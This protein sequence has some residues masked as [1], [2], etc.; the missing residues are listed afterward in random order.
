MVGGADSRLP[1][2][3]PPPRTDL[4][5]GT[6]RPA[7]GAEV[8][9]PGNLSFFPAAQVHP[10]D[11]AR[12]PFA[13]SPTSARRRPGRNS[14][15]PDRGKSIV[16]AG[17]A[18]AG[19]TAPALAV[20]LMLASALTL[21]PGAARAQDCGNPDSDGVIT[22]ADQA[23]A[24]G[25]SESNGN[26]PFT[27]VVGGGAATTVTAPTGA[28]AGILATG[29][30]G[31]TGNN[32]LIRVGSAGAVRIVKVAPPGSHR[33]RGVHL[34]QQGSGTATIDVRDTVTIGSLSNPM[35]GRGIYLHAQGAGAASIVS[36]AT[37]Y[38]TGSRDGIFLHRTVATSGATTITNSGDITVGIGVNGPPVGGDGLEFFYGQNAA[39]GAGSVSITNRGKIT[40]LGSGRGIRYLS[41]SYAPSSGLTVTNHGE[42]TATGGGYGM[43]MFFAAPNQAITGDLTIDNRGDITANSAFDIQ[44]FGQ[45]NLALMNTGDIVSTDFHGIR[46]SI[47]P[48]S[49]TSRRMGD[50]TV[51]SSG[52][53]SASGAGYRGIYAGTVGDGAVRVTARGGEIR[54]AAA[55]GIH[56]ESQGT[57]AVTVS[58]GADVTAATH[59]I[60]AEKTGS[61][62]TAGDVSVTATGGSIMA[63]TDGIRA[64]WAVD[65]AGNGGIEVTVDEGASVT[66]GAVGVHVANAGT[67]L[68]VR[69]RYT[70][71]FAMG[72][73]PDELVA[74][75]HGE[76]GSAV[77]LRNQLV[78]V[79]G[80]VTGGTGAAIHLE[81]GGGVLV[82]E[83]GEVRA[84]SSGVGIVAVGGP[85][86]VYVD[87]EVRGGAGGAAAVDLGGGGSVTVG[88]NGR[89][90]ANG[91]ASAIR[92]AV[93]ETVTVTLVIDRL[94]PYREDVEARLAGAL[95]GIESVR[96]REDRDGVPT[97]YDYPE[98]LQV[99]P[100]GRLDT[101][102]L[103]ARL[104]F[105]CGAAGD[106][107]CRMYEALPSMLLAMSALPSRAERMSAPRDARGGW[108]RVEVS[109]GEWRAKKAATAA[110]LAYDHS[111]VVARAGMDFVPRE[112]LRVGFS[113]HAPR[114][115]AEMPGVGE[116]ELDGVG[117]GVS[118]AWRF[119]DLYVDAQA[120]VTRY[121]VG[122]DSY[123][124]GKLLK[125]DASGVGYALGAEAGKRMPVGGAF[126]TPRAGLA[127]SKVD[128][129]EFTDLETAGGPGRSRVSLEDAGSV[130]GRV[131]VTVEKE[132][133]TGAAPGLLFGSLDVE[134]EFSDETEVKVGGQM[135]KTEVQPTAV[136]LGAGAMFDVRENVLMRAVAGYRASEGGASGYGGSLEVRVRF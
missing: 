89:V 107:R 59:G 48:G 72:E 12:D 25:I 64:F 39:S 71:G 3:P 2:P 134:R 112:D 114:G 37:I 35:T 122:L 29:P 85:A 123:A 34:N 27:L 93:G 57:G 62:A 32:V 68:M 115:K 126:V 1:P 79:R 41:T 50:V 88:L 103:P 113:M 40:V 119:G 46:A 44:Y 96:L 33:N 8:R 104:V 129:D 82:L 16:A 58:S 13:G 38:A 19:R 47:E 87:G 45:G 94:I 60:H 17:R 7:P 5:G 31:A 52:D 118:A 15:P 20:S 76:G 66:G 98:G 108:A 49:S 55:Q 99:G 26:N 133:G 53:V 21:A 70:P 116:V 30:S 61:G 83:G 36:A 42:I 80:M 9:T 86:L 10:M 43:R 74:A 124:H 23:W 110:K 63:T 117:A 121:E 75:M 18:P 97:G 78:T 54:S 91:A 69:R 101:S 11:R 128:L 67:G 4:N 14:R 131:G 95:P 73:D 135:L 81:G 102:A 22:C 125:K 105:S 90:L 51:T 120:A 111:W 136:S 130:K 6:R 84:G 24:G 77:A 109:R 132:V 100:E 56:A 28:S 127:W 92:G 106:G 65:A